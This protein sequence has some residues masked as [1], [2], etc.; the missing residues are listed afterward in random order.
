MTTVV[1]SQDD[2]T[3]TDTFMS[4]L[5]SLAERLG[6]KVKDDPMPISK[7]KSYYNGLLKAASSGRLQQI[8]RGGERFVVLT[9]EQVIA[10]VGASRTKSSL[11]D[12]LASIKAPSRPLDTSGAMVA[13]SKHDPYSLTDAGS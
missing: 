8:S 6:L 13:G 1:K 2:Q 9:E 12:T 11:A 5:H 3:Q 4:A 7:F 10:M